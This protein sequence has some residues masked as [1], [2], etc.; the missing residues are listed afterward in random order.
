MAYNSP[1]ALEKGIKAK[2]WQIL[3]TLAQPTF[4]FAISREKSLSDKEIYWMAGT[5]PGIKE[6]IE[7]ITYEEL[8][9]YRLEVKNKDWNDGILVERNTLD[10]SEIKGS[11]NM[12][13]KSMANLVRDFPDQLCQD[14]LVANSAAF[15]G[16]AFFADTR[17][18]ID[19]GGNVIDNLYPGTGTTFAQFSADYAGAKNQ[20]LGFRDKHDRAFN[21]KASLVAFVPQHLSDLANQLLNLRADRVYTGAAEISN[22][23]RGTAEIIINWEQG[24]SNDD[25]Y[26]VNKTN[27]IKPFLIQDRAT[28]KWTHKDDSE[29]KFLKYF[30]TFRMGSGFLNPMPIIKINN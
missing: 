23:Y 4:D 25:W 6:W 27:P 21:K 11:I 7:N 17:P 15:D 1:K 13:I 10:D 8:L 26:L 16:T 14:L 29:V 9:D 20:L 30:F 22:I 2:F 19:T 12:W 3:Q 28:T 5:V 24:A 18:N